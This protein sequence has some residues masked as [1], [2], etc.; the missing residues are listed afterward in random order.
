MQ[1]AGGLVEAIDPES[2]ILEA[3][4]VICSNEPIFENFSKVIR[5]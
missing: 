2:N 1:E 4:D 5:G 3:G